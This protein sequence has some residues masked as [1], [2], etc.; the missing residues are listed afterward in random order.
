MNNKLKTYP[1]VLG[2]AVF[3][4]I[5]LTIFPPANTTPTETS[6]MNY[7]IILIDNCEYIKYYGGTSTTIIHK[8]NCKNHKVPK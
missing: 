3:A 2:L 1:L 4:G 7:S 6:T 8:G 5:L